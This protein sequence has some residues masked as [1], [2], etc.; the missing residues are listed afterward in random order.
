MRSFFLLCGVFAL[1]GCLLRADS[2]AITASEASE[3][4]D[5]A[6]VSSQ[7]SELT[8]AS[9]DIATNFTI[10]EAAAQAAQDLQAFIVSQMPCAD[11]TLS[12]ATLTVVYGAKPG[13]CVY[14]GHTF[15]GTHAITITPTTDGVE[16][17]HTWTALSDG[18]V[19]VSGNAQVTWDAVN[20]SRHVVHDLSW[21]RVWDGRTGEGTA[22]LTQTPLTGGVLVGF[23]E[24]GTRTWDGQSGH[25]LLDVNDVQVRWADPVPQS[26]T[27]TLTTPSQKTA[28]LGFSRV[29]DS[30]IQ[31][32][33]TSGKSDYKFDVTETG[34]SS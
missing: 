1:N 15:S 13:L 16:V 22:D 5:E 27:Y 17:D 19:S 11:V 30:T 24:S 25:W 33:L 28:T 20:P 8:S 32:D 3:A 23:Q 10:G 7:A 26:G 2:S 29:N 18:V 9:I 31:V 34:Q 21:T 12:G 14:D 6:S 4:L